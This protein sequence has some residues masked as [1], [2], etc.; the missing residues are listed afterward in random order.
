MNKHSNNLRT[1]V[2]IDAR[3]ARRNYDTFRELVGKKVKLW[4]VVKSNAYGHG[5]YAFSE[6][7]DHA[8]VDGFCVDSVVEGLALRRT[9]VKKHIL[10][11]GPTL[12]ARYAEAAANGITISISTFEGLAALKKA[13]IVPDFHLKI[14][15]G[16]HRQGFYVEDVP[17]VVAFLK[18]AKAGIKSSLKGVFTHFA[19]AKDINYPSYTDMQFDK[20][21]QAIA[22]LEKAGFKDLMRHASATGGTLC[23]KK[24]HLDAVRVGIGLYGLWPSKELEVQLGNK[25]KLQPVLSWRAAVTEVKQLAAGDYVGYDLTERVPQKTMMAVLPIGYWHG[26][27]RSLSSMGEVLVRGARAKVLGRVSMDMTVV[28]IPARRGGIRAGDVATLIG[29]DGKDEIFAW[30]PSQR[31]GTTHYEFLTRLNPLMERVIVN[32]GDK[33]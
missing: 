27:P 15:T 17:K 29:R 2:E 12:P 1:W 4:S 24:Y 19:S 7:M 30:E 5:L 33:S 32:E 23:G 28:A 11:L 26:F 14:D 25:I 13:K 31:S 3:A 21:Q 8:G 18:N 9:G 22:L 10:V 20:L 6:V 16:M